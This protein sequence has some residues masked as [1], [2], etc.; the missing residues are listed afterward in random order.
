MFWR[1]TRSKAETGGGWAQEGVEKI[2][3]SRRRQG[4]TPCRTTTRVGAKESEKEKERERRVVGWPGRWCAPGCQRGL[5]DDAR[6]LRSALTAPRGGSMLREGTDPSEQRGNHPSVHRGGYT[7]GYT[8]E[9]R[10]R[11]RRR[12][13][14]PALR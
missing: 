9:A 2:K 10:R 4:R 7:P 6:A 1:Q 5:Y 3:A 14:Q 12:S 11:R 8:V 13:L